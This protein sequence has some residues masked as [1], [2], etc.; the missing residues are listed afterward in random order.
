MTAAANPVLTKNHNLSGVDVVMKAIIQL[1]RSIKELPTKYPAIISGYI[2]Y[3]Y[4]FSVMIRLFVVARH[5]TVRFWDVVELFNALPFMWL[6][7]MTWV[8]VLQMRTK[9]YESETLRITKEQEL[10]T[11]ETQISTMREV[12]LGL[13]HQVNNPLAIIALTLGKIRR[14]MQPSEELNVDINS[15][16]KESKR[17]AQALRDFSETRKY[18]VEQIG[19]T[20][21]TMAVTEKAE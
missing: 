18:A 15:I 16:E 9:L 5:T 20:I 1:F 8:K 7:A 10:Q 14:S 4:L 12:V 21:G 2:I 17:I 3:M 19:K 13:Q 11:K 6:L